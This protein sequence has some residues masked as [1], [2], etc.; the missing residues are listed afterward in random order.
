MS[1]EA[2]GGRTKHKYR[3][4]FPI[5]SQDEWVWSPFNNNDLCFRKP[6]LSDPKVV[7]RE[8]ARAFA[9]LG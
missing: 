1:H 9:A 8:M 3:L 2:D 7:E 4:F 5:D 6:N